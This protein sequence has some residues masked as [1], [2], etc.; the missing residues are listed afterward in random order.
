[1]T[2]TTHAAEKAAVIADT[3][4]TYPD[5]LSSLAEQP[6]LACCKFEEWNKRTYM[7]TVET[8]SRELM[9]KCKQTATYN[10]GTGVYAYTPAGGMLTCIGDADRGTTALL[11]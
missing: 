3:T 7:R 5:G 11:T 4:L 2:A 1:M 8:I 10:W 6:P 9:R